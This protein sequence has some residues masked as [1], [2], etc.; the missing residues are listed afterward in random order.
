MVVGLIQPDRGKVYL[1]D[2]DV[3]SVPM[4]RR[5]RRG[6]GYLAQEPSIFRKLTVEENVLAV[7]QM[8]GLSRAS[9]G[10]TGDPA[11]RARDQASP[12]HQGVRP[13]RR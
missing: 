13:F 3:T 4:Y 5:A 12:G 6:I 2:D 8:L 10:E 11:G 1:G 7:L 9:S